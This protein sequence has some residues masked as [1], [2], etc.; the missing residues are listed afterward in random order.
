MIYPKKI[1]PNIIQDEL[2]KPSAFFFF[3][4]NLFE[5]KYD[6]RNVR[7]LISYRHEPRRV[8]K[9]KTM[10]SKNC[11]REGFELIKKKTILQ[12]I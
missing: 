6:F 11:L 5:K 10:P 2:I 7:L 1:R 12:R 4:N 9:V 8:V 3:Q